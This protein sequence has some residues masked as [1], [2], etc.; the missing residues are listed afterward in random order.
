MLEFHKW[1]GM[2]CIG[3]VM[4][5][6]QLLLI[7]PSLLVMLVLQAGKFGKARMLPKV[8][9]LFWLAPYDWL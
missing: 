9:F 3:Q 2:V 4:T 8:K 1:I 5:T 6:S 7:E